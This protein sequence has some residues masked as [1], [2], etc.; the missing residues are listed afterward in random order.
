MNDITFGATLLS[1][2]ALI[3]SAIFTEATRAPAR[4]FATPTSVVARSNH[5]PVQVVASAVP[6][7]VAAR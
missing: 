4:A 1:I 5:P 3:A 2:L 6:S 7:K